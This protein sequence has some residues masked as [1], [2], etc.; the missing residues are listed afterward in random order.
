VTAKVNAPTIAACA[1]RMEEPAVLHAI[2]IVDA[3][4]TMTRLL[5]PRPRMQ[6]RRMQKNNGGNSIRYRDNSIRYLFAL[7]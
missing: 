3:T 4:R 6:R 2:L 5:M 1:S 7:K